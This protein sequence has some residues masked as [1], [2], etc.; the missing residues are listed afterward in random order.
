MNGVGSRVGDSDRSAGAL[1]EPRSAARYSQTMPTTLVVIPTYNERD[2]LEEIVSRTRA[3][4]PSVLVVDDNSPDGT[5]ELA[6]D[7]AKRDAGVSVLHRAGKEGLGAAY[8]AGF[9][10]AL[11]RGFDYIVE[12]DADGSHQPEQIPALIAQLDDGADLVIGTRWM[13]GGRVRN[14]PL[15]RQLLSKGGTRV[16]RFMLRSR[17]R[18]I[19]SGF[20]GFRAGTLA[21]VDLDSTDSQGYGFQVELAWRV[22]RSGADVREVPIEFVE[23]TQGRSKMNLGIVAEAMRN[24]IVWGV[25]DRVTREYPRP[26]RVGYTDKQ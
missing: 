22:E 7:L 24:V 1:P 6:D 16:A 14:W 5:G 3:Q 18:D 19:T 12:M 23:R 26:S 2:N 8:R 15:H 11:E 20:R 9:A 17:L 25:K 13:P 21:S 10:W 4:G